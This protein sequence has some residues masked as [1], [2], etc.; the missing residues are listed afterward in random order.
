[1]VKICKFGYLGGE[2]GKKNNMDGDTG[3][4]VGIRNDD[5]GL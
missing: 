2:N 4:I 5:F 1:M 3:N